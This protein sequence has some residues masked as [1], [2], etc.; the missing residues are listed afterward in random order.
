MLRKRLFLN[1]I[2]FVVLLVAVGVYAIFLFSHLANRLDVS[3]MENYRSAVA[4]QSIGDSVWFM[5]IALVQA[6]SAQKTNAPPAPESLGS[7]PRWTTNELAVEMNLAVLI[8]N[9]ALFE[10]NLVEELRSN[11]GGFH[12]AGVVIFGLD[13]E[14][15]QRRIFA[16]DAVPRIIDINQ[17]LEKIRKVNHANILATSQSIQQINHHITR[18]MIVGVAISIVI[19]AYASYKLGKSILGP[20][21]LLTK[22][23][24][25]IG[26]GSLDLTVPVLSNDELG[27]LANA[28]N[29]MAAQLNAYRRN[30]TEQ[31]VHLHRTMEATLASFPDPI[32]VLDGEG[33][34]EL[35]NP[36]AEDLS[37]RLELKD[38]LP[39]P[40]SDTT[41]EV[42]QTGRDFL[43]HSFKEVLSFPVH[44]EERFFLPRI[45]SMRGE[46]D[47]PLGVAVVLYDVTRFR[48]LDDAKT[49]LVATVSH[50]LKSPLTSVRMVLHLLLEKTIGPLTRKQDELL[51]T[52]RNDAERL[53]RILN[54]LLDMTRLEAGKSGLNQERTAAA[55]LVRNI[56]HEAQ[57]RIAEHG[58][59]LACSTEPRLPVVLVDRQRIG[60]VFRNFISN[61]VKHSPAGGEIQVRAA[62]ADGGVRFSVT[63]QGPGIP[64]EYL[65]R[66]FERFF[67]VPGQARTGAGLGLSIAREI[68]LAHGGRIGVRSQPGHGSEFYVVLASAE[69]EGG[70]V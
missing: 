32:F 38:A 5:E 67:R 10:T 14:G 40:L 2:P 4:A 12:A 22:A 31:I 61:A 15:E 46:G 57:S 24:R 23:T 37:A 33:R 66:I 36:A 3:A 70:T 52:A 56:A 45:L 58:L 62:P 49:N 64:E 48:L 19:C 63:D 53:L 59:K 68:V 9:A 43:P 39:A 34:I 47:K 8:K 28:F 42:L 26:Q 17:T 50:E 6:M 29:K 7:N 44:G 54:D 16:R 41:R 11:Y 27:E 35:K 20:I 55:E 18:L 25:E 69:E 60:L 1:L 13:Q 30:T 65:N 51:Q 21:Q